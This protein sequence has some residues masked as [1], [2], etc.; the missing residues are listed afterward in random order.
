M[1]L[2]SSWASCLFSLGLLMTLGVCRAQNPP[3]PVP[4]QLLPSVNAYLFPTI[5]AGSYDFCLESLSEKPLTMKLRFS[6]IRAEAKDEGTRKIVSARVTLLPAPLPSPGYGPLSRILGRSWTGLRW[7]TDGLLPGLYTLTVT[8]PLSVADDKGATI[9]APDQTSLAAGL[10]APARG[11]AS[12]S[13][14]VS[15]QARLDDAATGIDCRCQPRRVSVR[16][17]D[18]FSCQVRDAPESALCGPCHERRR[19]PRLGYVGGGFR[20]E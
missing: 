7:D 1:T 13:G 6:E 2:F 11:S 3:G 19:W 4:D 5:Q 10:S 17:T 9:S 20:D 16:A 8:V 12:G 15:R 18:V 14:K